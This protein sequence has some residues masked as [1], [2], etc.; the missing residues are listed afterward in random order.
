M[1]PEELLK[2]ATRFEFT[3]DGVTCTVEARNNDRTAW[4]VGLPGRVLN[5]LG[6]FEWEPSP[7]NRDDAFIARTRFDLPTA[8]SL[9]LRTLR[10][11]HNSTIEE[12][13]D[14]WVVNTRL[15]ADRVT[16]DPFPSRAAAVDWAISVEKTCNGL[17][18]IPEDFTC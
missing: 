8:I 2:H 17:D 6:D 11:R 10:R 15:Q 14:G 9:A 16:S 5:N 12:T 1:S 13:A 3:R 7:S 4:A 18:L